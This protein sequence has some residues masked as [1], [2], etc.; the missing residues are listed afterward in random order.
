MQKDLPK[1]VVVIES[2]EG[3]HALFKTLFEIIGVE[4]VQYFTDGTL[5]IKHVQENE[6][7]LLILDMRQTNLSKEN[8]FRKIVYEQMFASMPIIVMSGRITNAQLE[9]AKSRPLTTVLV[10]PLREVNLRTCVGRF[11]SAALPKAKSKK[12]KNDS[13]MSV[14]ITKDDRSSPL[15]ILSMNTTEPA[16][17]YIHLLDSIADSSFTNEDLDVLS[18]SDGVGKYIDRNIN[19]NRAF[20]YENSDES[21]SPGSLYDHNNSREDSPAT[22]DLNQVRNVLLVDG[23]QSQ[24]LIAL[25]ALEEAGISNID[26]ASNGQTAWQ[27]CKSTYYDLVMIDWKVRDHSA[28]TLYNRLRR[29]KDSH[30]QAVIITCG[31][32]SRE[33]FRLIE[34]NPATAVLEKP[35]NL[36]DLKRTIIKLFQQIYDFEFTTSRVSDAIARAIQSNK[37]VLPAIEDA[38]RNLRNPLLTLLASSEYLYEQQRFDEAEKVLTAALHVD[39]NNIH[40]L[41]RLGKVMYRTN[42]SAEAYGLL[43]R[44]NLYSPQNIERLCSLGEVGLSLSEPEK[45]GEHFRAALSIDDEDPVAK[46]G[47]VISENFSEFQETNY[48]RNEVNRK[49]AS[50]LNLIGITYI[51]S[52]NFE[53]GKSQYSAALAFAHDDLTMARLEFNM[54]LAFMRSKDF[55]TA[56]LWL[57][58]SNG[59]GLNEFRRAHDLLLKLDAF[60]QAS[61]RDTASAQDILNLKNIREEDLITDIRS[62]EV[63]KHPKT[64]RSQR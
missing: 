18:E 52:G 3:L 11:F 53:Q 17:D 9:A 39:P 54:G 12:K 33:D 13:N 15:D 25:K 19:K 56:R 50:I 51:R 59:R 47:V 37:P 22:G 31:F 38:I 21:Y 61:D 32:S 36:P 5:G 40:A 2:D 10:K 44:A 49:L 35:I 64:A 28:I 45:A 57:I 42:R 7:S 26:T 48:I 1:K 63:A 55:E 41:T 30:N 14:K 27:Y 62:T 58:K 4:D 29:N 23:D 43:S 34:D 24:R 6:P 60:I 46:A 8:I 20:E 16:A